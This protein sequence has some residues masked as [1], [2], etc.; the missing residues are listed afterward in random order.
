MGSDRLEAKTL[1]VIDDSTIV[2]FSRNLQT[3][4]LTGYDIYVQTDTDSDSANTAWK[5]GAPPYTPFLGT[6]TSNTEA[7]YEFKPNGTY[8]ITKDNITTEYSYLIRKNKLV[9]VTHG[10]IE[11]A[12]WITKP[13]VTETT[14]TKTENTISLGSITLT[15]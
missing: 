3:G 15:K 1:H 7:L 4:A 12:L 2:T 13:T 11:A 9:T 5:D 6:W 8:T 10:E 14:Y